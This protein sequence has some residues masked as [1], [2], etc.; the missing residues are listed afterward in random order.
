MKTVQD[1]LDRITN[2]RSRLGIS[3]HPAWYRGHR[4]SAY[5]LL[6]G[7]LRYKNGPKHERKLY[8]VF[9]NEGA[10]LIPDSFHSLE[11]LALMQHH[12]IPT[13]LLDWTESIHSALY[14]SVLSSLTMKIENPCIWILNPYRLNFESRAQNVIYDRDDRL[15][16]DYYDCATKRQWPFDLPVALAAPWRN[17]RVAAQKGY[18]TIHGNDLRPVEECAPSCVKRID[19]PQH[20]VRDIIRLLNSSA[21]NT[22]SQFPDLDGLSMKLRRQFKLF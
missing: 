15:D 1:L 21:T 14:F 6:P 16:L 22:F 10:S 5:K 4:F 7:L 18:F 13:R 20:L 3:D 9:R 19:I 2:Q 17:A 11:T 8:A 12:G